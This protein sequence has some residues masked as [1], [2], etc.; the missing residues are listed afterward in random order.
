MKRSEQVNNENPERLSGWKG[1]ELKETHGPYIDWSDP[2]IE[3][4]SRRRLMII[5]RTE[6]QVKSRNWIFDANQ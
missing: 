4:D 6:Y 3:F 2:Y 1:T 5:I